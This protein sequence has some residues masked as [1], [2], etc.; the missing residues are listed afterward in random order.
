MSLS[1]ETY[2]LA[3]NY[4]DSV[5]DSSGAGVVP[6]ITITAVQLEADEQP[7]VTKGGT[8]VNPTFELGIPK[9]K[10]GPQGL[11][12]PQGEQGPQG[13]AG[14]DAPQIDDTQASPSNPW[15]GAKVA[16]ELS[17]YAPLESAL[18]I[19]GIGSDM[20]SLSPTIAWKMQGLK[21]F[22]RTTQDGTPAPETPIPL[23]SA[24]ASGSVDITV[25]GGGEQSQS[26]KF[27]TPNGLPGIPVNSGGNFTDETGQQWICDEIDF[28]RGVYIQRLLKKRL[29]PNGWYYSSD[30]N[31]FY[32]Q[33]Q[34]YITS[35]V[36]SG[37][38]PC[39]GLCTHFIAA[40]SNYSTADKV[41]MFV[42]STTRGFAFRYKEL[43]G[44]LT[45]FTNFLTEN[46]VYIIGVKNEPVEIALT[47]E[48]LE[49][50]SALV[51][52]NDITNVVAQGCV[53]GATA[54]A[55]P[56]AYINGLI[57]RIAALE[58]AATNI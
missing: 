22:G 54:L 43:A 28:A 57:Q 1:V 40:K 17:K 14:Q 4:T 31:R 8:N 41:M 11:Q 16:M 58:S 18:T 33:D 45:L 52:Y 5:I 12:G 48:E 2:V 49:A 20:A 24:G 10:Q 36:V 15:S 25:S 53:V 30:T 50:Y 39:K 44:D 32:K 26:M 3:K 7:T 47:Q 21:L 34:D 46:E 19:S 6:N 23:V 9:G 27:A 13:P 35:N 51:S 37:Y 38:E 42:N 29:N 56:N 55:N